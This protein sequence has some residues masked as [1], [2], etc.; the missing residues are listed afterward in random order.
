ITQALHLP[1][2]WTGIA[3]PKAR[4]SMAQQKRAGRTRSRKRGS[5]IMTSSND[6]FWSLPDFLRVVLVA[7]ALCFCLPTYADMPVGGHLPPCAEW[8]LPERACLEYTTGPNG[9]QLCS[10]NGM[11]DICVPFTVPDDTSQEENVYLCTR[12]DRKCID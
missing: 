1:S 4:P 5:E 7:M 12:D 10:P 6:K 2:L 8:E 9:E 11:K 3:I